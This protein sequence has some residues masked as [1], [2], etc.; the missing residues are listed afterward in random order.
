VARGFGEQSIGVVRRTTPTLR[1]TFQRRDANLPFSLDGADSIQM[2]VKSR[3]DDEDEDAL[4]NSTLVVVPP[5]ENGE[6][7][8]KLSLTDTET[9]GEFYADVKGIWDG[10]AT[11]IPLE[12]FT[13]IVGLT[14]YN[15]S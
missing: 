9:L 8:V 11:V 4:F 1:F 7:Y 13:L 15:V 3:P 6:A 2:Y 12:Q 5:A 10:G 14:A